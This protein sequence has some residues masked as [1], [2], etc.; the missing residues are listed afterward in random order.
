[1]S[2]NIKINRKQLL[3][4]RSK[5]QKERLKTQLKAAR[6][7]L[8]SQVVAFLERDNRTVLPGK[9]DEKKVRKEKKKQKRI[10][11]DYLNNLYQKF[12]VENIGA[13]ISLSVFTRFRTAN[14]IM[15]SFGSRRTYQNM[16]LKD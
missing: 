12:R 11:K 4:I 10:L 16:A 6:E 5:N 7:E 13:K 1:M 3:K 9:R 15:A 8:I 2:R 14:F